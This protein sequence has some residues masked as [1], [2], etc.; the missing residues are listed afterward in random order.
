MV[1]NNITVNKGIVNCIKH[2]CAFLDRDKGFGM[3]VKGTGKFKRHIN[4][5]S[6]NR[7]VG[8]KSDVDITPGE[9]V[10]IEDM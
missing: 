9:E 5:N 8:K 2:E 10:K 1:F 6:G 4:P 7:C 3:V